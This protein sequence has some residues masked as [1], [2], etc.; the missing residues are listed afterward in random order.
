MKSWKKLLK[1]DI[2]RRVPNLRDDI[3]NYP[4]PVASGDD[5]HIGNGA[6]AKNRKPLIVW[7]LSLCAVVI[8]L[9]IIACSVLIKPVSGFDGFV[10]TIEINPTVTLTTDKNG[11]VTGISSSNADA[12]VI[13]NGAEAESKMKG[14]KISEAAVWYTDKAARLGYLNVQAQSAVRLSAYEKGEKI[15]QTTQSALENYFMDN[16]IFALVI[17]E[18]VNNENFAERSGVKD[19]QNVEMAAKFVMH[20][21]TLFAERQ[22]V[23]LN[24]KELSQL[25]EA[26]ITTETFIEKWSGLLESELANVKKNAED[27]Q[28]ICSLYLQIY[29]HKDNPA[30]LLKDYWNVKKYY[31]DNLS[32]EFGALVAEMDGALAG[33]KT[34]Y[35][36]EIANETDMREAATRYA[37]SSVDKLLA[38]VEKFSAELFVNNIAFIA[39]LLKGINVTDNPLVSVLTLPTTEDEFTRRIWDVLTMDYSFR[40]SKFEKIYGIPREKIAAD[41]Y[42][43][44][45]ENIISEYGTLDNFWNSV[46]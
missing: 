34:D 13:L 2:D 43:R 16:G 26:Y 45:R 17:A 1:E 23:G 33:Y 20:D 4:I 29:N 44:F 3:K 21:K 41:D 42:K 22:A 6:L 19:V 38:I 24:Q 15:L 9:V 30:M 7:L 28:R 36:V 11:T 12:D 14:K 39:D 32:G 31:G 18:T 35:G 40:E 25:Y 37:L 27:I 10:F 8:A 46:K 5:T